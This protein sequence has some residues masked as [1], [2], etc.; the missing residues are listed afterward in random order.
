MM[1]DRCKGESVDLTGTPTPDFFVCPS[2]L[3]ELNLNGCG[4]PKE[5]ELE[6]L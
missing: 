3:I 1:C 5:K 6:N 2:C 4:N